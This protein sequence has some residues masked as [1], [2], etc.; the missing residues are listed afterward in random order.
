MKKIIAIVTAVL[1]ICSVIIPIAVST[2]ATAG[3]P[4]TNLYNEDYYSEYGNGSYNVTF[5]NANK[6]ITTSNTQTKAMLKYSSDMTEFES[7]VTIGGNSAGQI[8]SGINFHAQPDD[9]NTNTF[10]TAGYCAYIVRK[11][12]SLNKA[13][14]YFQYCTAGS[15]KEE[16]RTTMTNS[17]P[18]DKDLKLRLDVSVDATN[19][20]VKLLSANGVTQ[21]GETLSYALDATAT[22]SDT[23]YYDQGAFILIGNGVNTYTNFSITSYGTMAN[24][25]EEEGSGSSSSSG[26][27]SGSSSGGE[28][29]PNALEE[30][31]DLYNASS[32]STGTD[33]YTTASTTSRAILKNDSKDNFSADLT[34]KLDSSAETK[35]GIVFRVTKVGEGNNNMQ[36]YAAIVDTTKDDY[37][38]LYLYKYGPATTTENTYLGRMGD[39]LTINNMTLTSGK[40]IGLHINVEDNEFE[41]YVYDKSNPTLKSATLSASLKTATDNETNNPV[42]YPTSDNYYSTGKIGLYVANGY[43]VDALNFAVSDSQDSGSGGSS[44]DDSSSDGSSSD[45]SDSSSDNSDGDSNMNALEAKYDLYKAVSF[46]TGNDGFTTATATSRAILKNGSKD[47]FSADLTI[48]LDSSAETKT[49]IV[50]RV[51]KVGEGNNNMQ[52]YAAIVDTTKDDYVRLYLYKYG[53]ATTTENTYLGRIGDFLTV[54]NM[55]LTANKEL[56]LHINVVDDSFEGYIYDKSNPSVKS[57]VLSESLKT[58]T[59]NETNKPDLYPTADNYYSTGKIGIYIANNYYVDALNFTVSDSQSGGSGDDSS[60]G[61]GSN[62]ENTEHDPLA[63]KFDL[64]KA[65]SFATGE[66]GYTTASTISRAILKDGS[67]DNFSADLVIK[68]NSEAE[69]KSGIVFRVGNVGNGGDN[70]QGYAA[71]VDTTKDDFVRLYLYKYG[72]TT[73]TKN[74]YMGRIG[75]YI[76]KND[77][78]LTADKEIVLHINVVDDM[79]EGY[80]YDKND[81]SVK[82]GMLSVSLK[83]ATDNE[84]NKP[85]EYPTANVYYSTGKIGIYFAPDMLADA[86]NF[87]IKDSEAITGGSGAG[88]DGITDP[89]A[90]KFDLYKAASFTT[91]ADGYTTASAISRAILKTGVKDSFSAELVIKLN[92]DAEAKAGIVFR[93]GNVGNGSD[94]MQGYAAIV[95]TTKDDFARLYLYKY[96]PATEEKNIYLGRLGDFVIE[97]GIELKDGTE[98]VLHINVV[99]ENFEGYIYDKNEPDVKSEKLV[100][101]LNSP[102]DNEKNN[103][104]KYPTANTYYSTGKIGIYLATDM[105]ADLLNFKVGDSEQ[106]DDTSGS[107]DGDNKLGIAANDNKIGNAIRGNATTVS[108]ITSSNIPVPTVE[109]LE[110]YAANFDN[111]TYYSSSTTNKFLRTDEG[112]TSTTAG[113]KRAI[114]DGVTVKGFHAAATMKISSEGTLRSGIIFRINNIENGLDENGALPANNLE[115]YAA[116]LYKTPGTTESNARVVLCIYKYG[117][118]NG[119]HQYLGT[120]ASKASEIPLQ[121]YEKD[122]AAAAGQEL[123]IDVNVVDDQLTAYFYNT[124]DPSLKSEILV[125]ELTAETDLE[126]STPSLKGVAF[127]SGAIGLTATDY[128]TFTNFTV[129][130]PIYPSNEVGS[131]AELDSYMLYGSGVKQEGEYITSNSSGTK[132]LIVN[133]LTVDDFTASVDMTIDPNGNLKTG[134]FFRV[135]EV[136]NGADD[137]TGWAIV[138]TRNY[139]TNGETNPNRIDIVLFKWGYANGKLSY[140]GE[141]AREVYKSGASFVDGKMAGEELTFVVRVKGAA[142]DATLYHKA[143]PDNKP[144]TFSTNLKFAGS[145]EK[146]DVAYFESGGIGLYLG[147]S[148]SDPVNYNKVR[149]FHIDDGSGVLVKETAQKGGITQFLSSV[150]TTGEGM[151]VT[152]VAIIFVA[153]LGALVG[154]CVYNKRGKREITGDNII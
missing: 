121:G 81:P 19:V 79:F 93:V 36:G 42:S 8:W 88:E 32:F 11:S 146:G 5:D 40:E 145:K 95:D 151:A 2:I 61:D 107:G 74:V 69:T 78:T 73:D 6:I 9:F 97:K 135:N 148:V 99:G 1:L 122:I 149:N 62:E 132:K 63:K 129:S 48:K 131:L 117:I 27:G 103:P 43:F 66:D 51:T 90:K 47:N 56:V 41:G 94:N 136:A 126:K 3:T 124:N 109:E 150:P 17:L 91:G 58:A 89:L 26:S 54:N 25:P 68:L 44:S 23:S 31:Y 60:G 102:T 22:Y 24:I 143:K 108:N 85:T 77:M 130:E 128:V 86:L 141:V 21:Y 154:L 34:I 142:I 147:N 101:A 18:T 64:Y 70:M 98:L 75:D 4:L 14:L 71:I 33:G 152:V 100:T 153:A 137:Q 106:L 138:V 115:G 112:I 76:L 118:R 46:A 80:I 133:N 29:T 10:R 105:M 35:T 72:P 127:E 16:I 55:T 49:G 52:G 104:K 45:S 116:I 139:A 110:K 67:K 65:T 7:S 92:S 120:I 119:K 39:F 28:S 134:F 59:D 111:Y 84:R 113:A 87:T 114:L 123:T 125:T 140:L 57:A 37:V 20:T 83:T 15:S 53:P 50:F 12:A 144:V 38:R 13:E 30:K 96:G 82:S